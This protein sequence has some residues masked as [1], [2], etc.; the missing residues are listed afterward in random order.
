[1]FTLVV[2][3]VLAGAGKSNTDHLPNV[4]GNYVVSPFARM[5]RAVR[6]CLPNAR[7]VGTLFAPAEVN[8]VFYKDKLVEA[9]R[10]VGIEVE[11]VGVSTASEVV[12]AA[13]SLCSTNIDA[14]CQ[15]SDNLSGSTFAPIVQASR[16]FRLPLFSFNTTH[17]QQGSVL[18][19]ARDYYDGGREAGLVAAR[20]MRGENPAEIP[21]E[22]VQRTR[23]IINLDNARKVGLRIPAHLIEQADEVIGR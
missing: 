13:L 17:S 8:S 22:L 16:R 4:A 7:R 23:F 9:A 11:A 15:I 19:V 2:N 14:M 5:M 1:M 12:D 10:E 18:M 3:P 6:E 21:F 20:V